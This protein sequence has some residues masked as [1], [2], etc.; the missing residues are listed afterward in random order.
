MVEAGKCFRNSVARAEYIELC[1]DHNIDFISRESLNWI[2][3]PADSAAPQL[4][5]SHFNLFIAMN[6]CN[7]FAV[8]YLTQAV[9]ADCIVGMRNNKRAP[10]A[11]VFEPAAGEFSFSSYLGSLF[12]F[13]KI[14]NA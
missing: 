5:D 7:S 6:N 1:K 9:E 13:L 3:K 8:D 14:V 11:L 2:G 10:Y 12:D 4:K